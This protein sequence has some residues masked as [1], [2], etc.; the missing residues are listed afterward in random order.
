MELSPKGAGRRWRLALECPSFR[1][2][3]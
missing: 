1:W 3:A 2:R